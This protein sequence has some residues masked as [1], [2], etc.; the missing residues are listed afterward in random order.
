ME[1]G[2]NASG[3]HK[4]CPKCETH[5]LY[6]EF[7]KNRARSDGLNSTCR[8]CQH[9]KYY[10]QQDHQKKLAKE[11]AKKRIPAYRRG[12]RAKA[13]QVY[14]GKCACCGETNLAFLCIDHIRGGASQNRQ[15]NL[16]T[17]MRE[18]V[19]NPDHDTYQVLCANCNMA[20]ERAEGCPHQDPNSPDYNPGSTDY[21]K[22]KEARN[23]QR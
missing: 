11:R 22:K 2:V 1:P 17:E 9:A 12:W 7:N 15:Q 5:K 21:R 14:G 16:Y 20:K 13:I 19:L 3:N 18:A 4:W 6:E 10:R 8:E 23:A